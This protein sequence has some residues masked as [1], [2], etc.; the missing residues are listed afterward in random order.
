MKNNL[1]TMRCQLLSL[2]AVLVGVIALPAVNEYDDCRRDDLY[3]SLKKDGEEFCTMLLDPEC[4]TAIETPVQYLT[5]DAGK[6]S[7]YV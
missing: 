5:Y 2:L 4:Y 6:L 7:S 3:K 1:T